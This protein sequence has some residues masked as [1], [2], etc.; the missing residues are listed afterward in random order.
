MGYIW[1]EPMKILGELE[2]AI[3]SSEARYKYRI[4]NLEKEV[5]ELKD[6][7][8]KDEMIAKLTKERCEAIENMNRGFPI[9]KEEQ[10]G[11]EEWCNNHIKT[12][13]GGNYYAGTIGGRWTYTFIPTSI[14]I[15]GKIK[16]S[17]CE[18]SYKFQDLT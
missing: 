2:E 18:E 9:T 8:I 13:H 12:K 6:P 3:N 1:K 11:I 15:I 17:C 7:L 14:G 4:N 5:K 16:C 10:A